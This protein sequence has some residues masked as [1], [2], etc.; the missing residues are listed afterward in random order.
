M[1]KKFVKNK[2]KKDKNA[3][4]KLINTMYYCK[5]CDDSSGTPTERDEWKFGSDWNRDLKP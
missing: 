4:L 3:D 2:K 1:E 5:C